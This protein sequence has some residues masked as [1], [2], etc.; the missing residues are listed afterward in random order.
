MQLRALSLALA[1]TLA[2][3]TAVTVEE[4]KFSV[5]LKDG[6]FDIRDYPALTIAEVTVTGGQWRAAN[7]GFRLLAGYIFGGN[8]RRQEI[9]MT[10]PVVQARAG[11]TIPM[12]TPVT[13]TEG[14][15]GW[16]VRFIMPAGSTPDTLPAPNEKQVRL[17][18]TPPLRQAVVKFSGWALSGAVKA[19]TDQLRAWMASRHLQPTGPATLAQYNPPWTIW[20]LR[21]NELMIPVGD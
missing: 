16:V 4:P 15:E 14:P 1:L 10:A 8:A 17:V 5:V 11:E 12:T 7:K 3:C 9:P 2:G 18:V 6:P 20:F 21:R 13:Q 19:R